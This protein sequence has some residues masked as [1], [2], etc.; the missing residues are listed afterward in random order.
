MRLTSILAGCGLAMTLT[1]APAAHA[2]GLTAA[3]IAGRVIDSEGSPIPGVSVM[4]TADGVKGSAVPGLPVM[5]TADGVIRGVTDEDGRFTF[6]GLLADAP[7]TLR[8]ELQGFR[9]VTRD[10]LRAKA[11]ETLIVELALKFG[12]FGNGVVLVGQPPPIDELLTADA[13]VHVRIT[14]PGQDRMAET[15]ESCWVANEAPAAI[16]GVARSARPEWQTGVTVALS[17]TDFRLEVGSEYLMFLTYDDVRQQ[18][19]IGYHYEIVGSRVRAFE[20]DGE[21][22]FLD[23]SPIDVALE[24]LAE[25][26]QRHSRYR[27]YD[28]VTSSAALSTLSHGTGWALLGALEPDRDVWIEVTEVTE[29]PPFDFVQ[30]P[31]SQR[32]LPRVHDRIRLKSR[33]RIYILDFGSRGET[34]RNVRPTSRNG[35][36]Q[37]FDQT[38]TAVEPGIVYSVA[39]ID[40]EPHKDSAMRFVWVRLVETAR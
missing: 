35:H 13:V 7:Y 27:R 31:E 29:G 14:Q 18:F 22:G 28:D 37:L 26:Y 24:R 23:G 19:S 30:P 10:G 8:T 12:C 20:Q 39:D 32:A 36:L 2:Q 6:A 15:E 33:A 34:L 38:G 25:T 4:L 3:R 11:G 5:A 17:S 1:T 16:L 9:A 21:L 40:V